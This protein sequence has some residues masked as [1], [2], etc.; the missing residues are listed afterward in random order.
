MTRIV[1]WS[2][3]DMA[4]IKGIGLIIGVLGS[5]RDRAVI[6]KKLVA[7]TSDTADGGFRRVLRELDQGISGVAVTGIH[8]LGRTD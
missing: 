6:R 4:R 2:W 3:D 5:V 7:V 8:R 1:A